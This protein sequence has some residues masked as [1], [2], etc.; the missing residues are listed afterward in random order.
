M[1]FF[2]L[3]CSIL[4][5]AWNF[6]AARWDVS[7]YPGAFPCV[8][9][10]QALSQG[11]PEPIPQ[12]WLAPFAIWYL[13]IRGLGIARRQPPLPAICRFHFQAFHSPVQGN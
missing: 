8:P 1:M 2:S 13:D 7:G 10:C 9:A 12:A 5:A 11:D 4:F 6:V 3:V